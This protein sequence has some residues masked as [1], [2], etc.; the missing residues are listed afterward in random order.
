MRVKCS[1]VF[2]KSIR[3]MEGIGGVKHNVLGLLSLH[4]SHRSVT[5]TCSAKVEL[6][7]AS[8]MC[9]SCWFVCGLNLNAVFWGMVGN[10]VAEL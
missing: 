5:E 6:Q 3:G 1:S 4:C 2:V 9:G 10:F 7:S 8:P